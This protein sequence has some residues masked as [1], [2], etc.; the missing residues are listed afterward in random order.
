M[1]IV[2]NEYPDRGLIK[3]REDFE[4][5]NGWNEYQEKHK[6]YTIF[7]ARL[8]EYDKYLSLKKEINAERRKTQVLLTPEENKEKFKSE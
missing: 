6:Q 5:D 8:V 1:D 7:Q 3:V 2:V 4:T